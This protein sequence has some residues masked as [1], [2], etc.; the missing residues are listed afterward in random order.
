MADPGVG[1]SKQLGGDSRKT[2]G[3]VTVRREKGHLGLREDLRWG[4]SRCSWCKVARLL[5]R[6]GGYGD[7]FS[8]GFICE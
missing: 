8:L 6:L 3:E 5:W 2:A 4:G 7:G 1:G